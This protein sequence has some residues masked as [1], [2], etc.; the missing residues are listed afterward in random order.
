MRDTTGLARHR[1]ETGGRGSAPF[2][3]R[4]KAVYLG[5][6]RLATF[7]EVARDHAAAD[8]ACGREWV[9]ACAACRTVRAR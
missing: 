2:G 5:G 9:C 8:A 7:D 4:R 1:K 6:M 3:R